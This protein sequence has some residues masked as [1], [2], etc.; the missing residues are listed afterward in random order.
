[1]SKAIKFILTVWVLLATMPAAAQLLNQQWRYG[2]N[3]GISFNT[4]PPSGVS[5]SAINT[6]EGSAAVS[7]K[8]TGALLFYTDGVTVWDANNVPMPNGTGLM[9]GV[10]ASVLPTNPLSSTSAAVIVPKPFNDNIYYII[11]TDQEDSDKGLRYSVVDMS[12]HGGLG[13]VVAGQKNIFIYDTR[14]EKIQVVPNATGCGYWLISH[15]APGNTFAAFRIDQ[16]GVSTSPVLSTTGSNQLNGRGHMKVNRQRTKIVMGNEDFFN[17]Q[18]ELFN[19]D[20]STGAISASLA[21]RFNFAFSGVSFFGLEFSPDGTRLYASDYVKLV[22]YDVSLATAAQIEASAVDLSLQTNFTG[23]VGAMQLGPDNRI[24]LAT[25]PVASI[26]APNNAG[27]ACN[28]QTNAITNSQGVARLGL[29]QWI[30]QL[31][32]TLPPNTINS[33]GGCSGDSTVFSLSNTSF[34]QS[35]SWNFDDPASEPANNT[36]TLLSPKHLYANAGVYNVE[37][38]VNYPCTTITITRVFIVNGTATPL[39]NPVSPICQGAPLTALPTTSLDGITGTWSPALNNA[40]TTTYIF[41]PD[42]ASCAVN[43]TLTITVNPS[44]AP[45]FNPIPPFCAGIVPPLLPAT[46]NNGITG[47]WSPATINNSASGIYTFTPVGNSCATGTSLSVTVTP[48]VTPS[49][50]LIPS[51]CAGSTAPLLPAISTNGIAGTWSPAVI[52]NSASGS[53]TFTPNAGQCATPVQLVITVNVASNQILFNKTCQFEQVHFSLGNTSSITAVNWTFGEPLLGINNTAT[54]FN[55]IHIYTVPGSYTVVAT[56]TGNCGA[57]TVDTVIQVQPSQALTFNVG[58]TYIAGAA[59]PPLPATSISGVPGTWLPPVIDNLNS[60]TYTF[61]P[62]IPGCYIDTI[63]FVDIVNEITPTFTPIIVVCA[64]VPPPALPTTSLNGITGTWSPAVIDNSASAN[65][66]FTPNPGQ[67]AGTAIMFIQAAPDPPSITLVSPAATAA[68]TVCVGQ[69]ITDIIYNLGGPAIGANINGLPPGIAGSITGDVLTIFG[70][71]VSGTNSPYN[72]TIITTGG[73]C[74]SDTIRGVI[75]VNSGNVPTFANIPAICQGAAAPVL[76]ALSSNG[77]AGTWLPA[78][79]SNSASGTYTFTPNAGQCA[80]ASPVQLFISVI[81]SIA[82]TFNP[83]PAICEGSISPLLPAVSTNGITGTWNPAIINNSVG[84]NYTFTPNA[85]QCASAFILPVQVKL[86][87]FKNDTV[88]ICENQ[89]PYLWNGNIYNTAGIYK[90]TLLNAAGCDSN[91]TLN[92]SVKNNSFSNT[93]IS[94]CIGQFPYLWNENIYNTAGIY[95][96]TLLNAEGCDSI[97]TLNLAVKAN[98]FSNTSISICSGQL[99]YLWNGNTYIAGGTYNDTLLNAAGCDSIITLNLQITSSAGSSTTTVNRCAAQLP[100]NWNGNSYP[101]FGSYQATL[102]NNAGCDSVAN[103]I[104]QE[105]QI[106]PTPNL[107]ADSSLCPEDILFLNPGIFNTYEWQD[108]SNTTTYRVAASGVYRVTVTDNNGCVGSATKRITYQANCTDIFFPNAIAPNG[109]STNRTFGALGNLQQLTSYN[110]R[111][112]NRYGALI[113]STRN[114]TERWNGLEKGKAA[115]VNNF[116]W[117][118]EYNSSVI[119]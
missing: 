8:T 25:D 34:I 105:T 58:S 37:A 38:V 76:P 14:S 80:S 77:I 101:N 31:D 81:P 68:Q 1:M 96:D 108:L 57:Y 65:Y 90:D 107:G 12:L 103:L 89:F 24:Y 15:D 51:F 28:L 104:L 64:G 83:I 110:L 17:R 97:L 10:P 111:I 113:F 13:D 32:V 16:L 18:I 98:S 21:W 19:F 54:G 3:G 52:S 86:K 49:F 84:G 112:Y 118:S 75:N 88:Q 100:Y 71:P 2:E 102:T 7:D 78:T 63:I 48:G 69:S 87:S 73:N 62:S 44:G 4:T 41:T 27:V 42:G 55:P 116:V 117:V 99:P 93:S 74:G 50:N 39:F 82:P 35:I 115:G 60:G 43:T 106:T 29:P 46:S 30:Y 22:Q 72:Y 11:T 36:S 119:F 94:I 9:G 56:I 66:T 53:Y 95:K 92:L 20:A 40:T 109:T 79:V 23:N 61:S 114:P 85:G 67:N 6:P 70:F 5:G 47:V 26:N 91:L 33:A 45:L 59:V